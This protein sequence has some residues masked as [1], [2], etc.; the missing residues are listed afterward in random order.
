[1]FKFFSIQII[2]HQIVV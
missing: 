2:F 1:M